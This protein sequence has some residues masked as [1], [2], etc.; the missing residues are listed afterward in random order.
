MFH[1]KTNY[2]DGS[3]HWRDLLRSI[4]AKS[5]R[6]LSAAARSPA[7]YED[8]MVLASRL[9]SSIGEASGVAV[10]EALLRR[11]RMADEPEKSQFFLYLRDELGADD[12]L[13]GAAARQY[14]QT[15][16]AELAANLFSVAEPRR[17]EL[18]RRLNLCPGGTAGIVRMREDLIAL[19][20]QTADLRFVDD[21]FQHLLASWFNRGFLVL[22]RI[23]WNTPAAILEKII[24]YEAVHTINGW[25]DLRRRTDPSDRRLYAF[26][27]P[28]LG[29]EPLIFVE[30]ALMTEVPNAIR[31]ILDEERTPAAAEDASVAV[32][33][34]ITNC[35][36][37][38]RGI[39]FGNFLI[40]QVV[41]DLKAELPNLE[42]FVTLSPIPGFMRWVTSKGDDSMQSTVATA[43]RAVQEQGEN[44]P[45]DQTI[46]DPIMKLVARY[47]TE[48]KSAGDRPLDP[49]AKFHLGNGAR[50]ERINWM[51]DLSVAGLKQ[52]AGVM[53]NYMYI[54]S[55]LETNHEAFAG[56]G[57]VKVGPAMRQWLVADDQSRTPPRKLP[58][59]AY[60]D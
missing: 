33:Y 2:F 20:K 54:L 25:Q 30:V 11:Y 24:H 53:V 59:L 49:V 23:D 40:K 7:P 48:E 58:M 9:L 12:I 57:E 56:A 27:H 6:M 1:S 10:A 45:A 29:D 21:D 37:G 36:K 50:L 34:S 47:L 16:N 3:V 32:F 44:V 51:G 26:F 8:L 43:I 46:R 17:Q 42:K 41:Q 39:S 19:T 60:R 5:R 35:Q 18:L 55:D 14:L 31:P 22:R 13:L 38:L 4:V 28:S 15:P 52:S